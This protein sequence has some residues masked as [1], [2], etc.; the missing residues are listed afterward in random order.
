[1]LGELDVDVVDVPASAAILL[2]PNIIG[3]GIFGNE[4][5]K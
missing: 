3:K 4:I 2:V 5:S 1:M